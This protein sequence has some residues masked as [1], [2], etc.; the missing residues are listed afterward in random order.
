MRLPKICYMKFKFECFVF[1]L[2]SLSNPRKTLTSP[3]LGS[4]IAPPSKRDD[5]IIPTSCK[6]PGSD[7]IFLCFFFPKQNRIISNSK[8][9]VW[10]HEVFFEK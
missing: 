9:V 8:L 5:W 10:L 4:L 3:N 2:L 7:Y 1:C 6:L